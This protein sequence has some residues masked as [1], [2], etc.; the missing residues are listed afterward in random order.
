MTKESSLISKLHTLACALPL[1]VSISACHKIPAEASGPGEC[2]EY[3]EDNL[4][5]LRS[6]GDLASARK[7]RDLLMECDVSMQ[8]FDDALHWAK[9]AAESGDVEDKRV[10]DGLL[11]ASQKK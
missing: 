5:A 11:Q 9:V 7:M 6:K 3:T 4:S 10:Y 2:R 1:A 8:R